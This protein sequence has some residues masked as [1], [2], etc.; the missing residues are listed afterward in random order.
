MKYVIANWKAHKTL[1]EA[2]EWLRIFTAYNLEQFAGVLEIV[3]CVPAY[4]LVPA[5][6]AVSAFPHISLGVQD[7]S[8]YEAGA[9]TGELPAEL[10]ADLADYTLIGHSE[11]RKYQHEDDEILG[12]KLHQAMT[13]G[14]T[15]IYCIRSLEDKIPPVATWVAYEPQG[16]IGNGNNADVDEVLELRSKLTHE[17]LEVFIYGG[18]VTHEN[19]GEYLQHSEID[20]VLPGTDSLDVHAFYKLLTAALVY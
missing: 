19:V 4:L 2:E 8:A 18:S 17:N 11:R 15:P 6:K 5:H 7:V 9:Y 12:D 3:L 16:S 14:M 1:H 10:V 20:G 13:V